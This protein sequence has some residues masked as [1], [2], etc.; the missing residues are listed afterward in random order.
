[1][2]TLH[3][4]VTTPHSPKYYIFTASL[5]DKREFLNNLSKK[6][7]H[8]LVMHEMRHLVWDV[9]AKKFLTLLQTKPR[10]SG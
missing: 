8:S 10:R 1:M 2:H 7:K 5:R 9:V 3:H 6:S 4:A